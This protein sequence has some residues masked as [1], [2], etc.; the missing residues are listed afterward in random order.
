MQVCSCRLG[1]AGCLAH[2]HTLHESRQHAAGEAQTEARIGVLLQLVLAAAEQ[3]VG[4]ALLDGAISCVCAGMTM[5]GC[6]Q[7]CRS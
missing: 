5:P 1:V 4:T 2:A 6:A 3:L 7:P